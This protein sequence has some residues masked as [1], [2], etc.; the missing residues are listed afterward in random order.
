MMNY[1]ITTP[2]HFYDI[3]KVK[4]ENEIKDTTLFF[5][6]KAANFQKCMRL[7]MYSRDTKKDQTLFNCWCDWIFS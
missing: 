2:Q 1:K 5:H 7:F 3:A 6:S 4:L